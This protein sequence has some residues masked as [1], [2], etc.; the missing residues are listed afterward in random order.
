M[1]RY[2]GIY[3]ATVSDGADPQGL[4]RARVRVKGL[5]DG[6]PD[7]SLP[8]AVQQ[9]FTAA[10]KGGGSAVPAKGAKV[11]V[12]FMEGD[13][14]FPVWAGGVF[15]SKGDLPKNHLAGRFVIY[16]SPDKSITIAVN[17]TLDDIEIKT[18]S[19]NTTLGALVDALIGHTHMTPAGASGNAGT[20]VPPYLAANF[21]TGSLK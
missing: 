2:N 12:R 10:T 1:M 16:E 5:H 9:S 14:N 4:G 17:E 18:T 15:E 13:I 20:G 6:I 11:S 8:W 3:K 21:Q 7:G 19:Y